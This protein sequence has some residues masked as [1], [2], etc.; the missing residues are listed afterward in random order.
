[1]RKSTLVSLTLVLA[2]SV[3]G[4]ACDSGDSTTPTPTTPGATI[5]E[6]F[7]GSLTINGAVTFSFSTTG[8][9]TLTATLRTVG[10]NTAT[11]IGLALGTWNGVSC[12]VQI[13]NDRSVIGTTVTG[14]VNAAGSLCARL[15]DVGQLTQ[16]STFEIVVVHP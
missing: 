11:Q 10:P 3:A 9:G 7:S 14:Q 4:S 13:S 15:Y 16:T 5:T 8:S 6:T 1:M 2:L 12:A